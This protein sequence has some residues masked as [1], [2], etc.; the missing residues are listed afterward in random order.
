MTGDDHQS[1]VGSSEAA[2]PNVTELFLRDQDRLR[3]TVRFRLDPRLAS[4][5]D[6]EDVLQEAFMEISRRASD[7]S[8]KVTVPFF[9]WA[10]QITIQVLIDIHRKHL[11]AVRRNVTRE[12]SIS[13]L[14]LT[15][16]GS[17]V[18]AIELLGNLTSPSEAAVRHEAE[19]QLHTVLEQLS[20]TDREVLVLRHLEE[21]TNK[22]VAEVL[23]LHKSAASRR[24]LRA[25]QSLRAAFNSDHGRR[26]D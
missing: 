24:Y 13:K 2:S 17:S 25:L 26:E 14:N 8:T 23:G 18:L 5:V 9:V 1:E 4:R 7:F 10:R 3:K 22:E 16:A 11:G 21:L 6:C 12:V 19:S 15:P 20:E